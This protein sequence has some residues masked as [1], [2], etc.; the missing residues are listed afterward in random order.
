MDN[1]PERI[2]GIFC[3]S[4][5]RPD[6]AGVLDEYHVSYRG[7]FTQ[8]PPRGESKQRL[9]RKLRNLEISQSLTVEDRRRTLRDPRR[10]QY[11]RGRP[12]QSVNSRAAGPTATLL[13]DE[14]TCSGCLEY[15]ARN[16]F[17]QRRIT[18][19]CNHEYDVCLRCLRESLGA[20]AETKFW[21]TMDCPECRSRLT[22]QDI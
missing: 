2:M 15:L 1:L 18:A 14:Y 11:M 9:L 20:Q 22:F 10:A 12:A 3:R 5:K 21:Q 6:V 19:K 8:N 17:P 4:W 7:D 13:R 16:S